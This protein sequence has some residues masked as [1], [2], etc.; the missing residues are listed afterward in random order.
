MLRCRVIAGVFWGVAGASACALPHFSSAPVVRFQG[1]ATDPV[2]DTAS[3][4]DARVL[5]PADLIYAS[6]RITDDELRLS[7]RFAPGSFDPATTGVMFLLDTDL[8]S[9]TGVPGLGVGAEYAVT[10]EAQPVRQATVARAVIDANCPEGPPCR[11][12]PFQRAKI[13]V[14][15]DAMEVVVSRRAFTQFDGRANVRVVAFASL[16]GG[17]RTS[18]SDHMPNLPA[19]FIEVR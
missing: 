1:E 15:G 14:S 18:T 19:R 3:V 10:L 7:V 5:R 2:G 13:V 12:E 6:V 8:D 4:G 16:D 17:R 11:Y 9:A